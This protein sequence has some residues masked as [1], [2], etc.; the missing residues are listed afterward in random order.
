MF[1]LPIKLTVPLLR[2]V[3][4]TALVLMSCAAADVQRTDPA[5]SSFAPLP[6]LPGVTYSG[7]VRIESVAPETLRVT[8][9]MG[10]PSQLFVGRTVY[11]RTDGPVGVSNND[12]VYMEFVAD[13]EP[14]GRH[15]LVSL[16]RRQARDPLRCTG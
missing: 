9:T 4:L 10:S 11:L 1:R 13:A 2:A 6:S 12:C 7:W 5:R 3:L 16:T 15:K 14:D 8:P